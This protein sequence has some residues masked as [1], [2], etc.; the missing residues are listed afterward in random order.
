MNTFVRILR[1]GRRERG[2][3]SD[4]PSPAGVVKIRTPETYDLERTFLES[5]DVL[6]KLKRVFKESDVADVHIWVPWN[7]LAP[8]EREYGYLARWEFWEPRYPLKNVVYPRGGEKI[9][10]PSN[11]PQEAWKQ[12][13]VKADAE[14][15]SID[16]YTEDIYWLVESGAEDDRLTDESL[17]H[18]LREAVDTPS[19][20]MTPADEYASG[21]RGLNP[22]YPGVR[23]SVGD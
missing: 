4:D 11:W 10:K 12:L 17:I 16:I 1:S 18:Y 6:G 7:P 5:W 13:R 15:K 8:E 23:Y 20:M 21:G 9:V 22:L 19:T 3:I 14:N 2:P